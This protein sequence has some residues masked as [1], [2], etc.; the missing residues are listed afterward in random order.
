[1][2]RKKEINLNIKGEFMKTKEEILQMTKAELEAYKISDEIKETFNS[3]NYSS[4]FNCSNCP[5][6][7]GCLSCSDCQNCSGCLHCSNCSNCL[8]CLH[9]S[10]CSD[11]LHCSN[12]SNCSFCL[13]CSDCLDCSNCSDCSNCYLCK[14][15]EGKR[16]AICNMEMSKEEYENKMKELK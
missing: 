4:C 2:E 6:S 12:C 5:N 11:S 13:G 7:S 16:Y 1:M 14:D 8:D 10:E 3:K 15:V 9:C